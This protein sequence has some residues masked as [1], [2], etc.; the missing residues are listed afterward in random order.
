MTSE[1][2]YAHIYVYFSDIIPQIF[3]QLFCYQTNE[4][5]MKERD[6]SLNFIGEILNRKCKWLSEMTTDAELRT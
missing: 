6:R 2:L 4:D 5:R 1:T 3:F